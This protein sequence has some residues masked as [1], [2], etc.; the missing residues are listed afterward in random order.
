MQAI[1]G[2]EQELADL[3]HILGAPAVDMPHP[4]LIYQISDLMRQR[5]A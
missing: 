2:A 4:G 3:R 1:P 5:G